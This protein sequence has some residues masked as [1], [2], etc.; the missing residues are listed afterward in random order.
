M[1]KHMICVPHGI[2]PWVISLRKLA[3]RLIEWYQRE[4]SPHRVH[5]CRY[6]PS[7]SEYG[8]QCYLKFNF[9]KASWLTF[10]RIMR[11]N[12]LF[13][14]GYDPVPE[15]RIRKKER[16]RQSEEEQEDTKTKGE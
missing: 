10:W 1:K 15:K 11:C 7:C 14:G 3:V 4:I 8:K 2:M 12:P 9:F 13:K 5:R 6:T 16:N